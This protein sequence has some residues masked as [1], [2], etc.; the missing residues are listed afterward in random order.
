[1]LHQRLVGVFFTTS[2]VIF[3]AVCVANSQRL[4]LKGDIEAFFII[5]FKMLVLILIYIN[6]MP[7]N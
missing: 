7:T 2:A 1:M 6:P 4:V 3:T 5:N